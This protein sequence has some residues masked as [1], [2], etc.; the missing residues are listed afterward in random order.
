MAGCNKDVTGGMSQE[1]PA[2]LSAGSVC[3]GARS[4]AV[5]DAE[6][7]CPD[8]RT[9]APGQ[10]SLPISLR[11]AQAAFHQMAHQYGFELWTPTIRIAVPACIAAG[12][13]SISF[14]HMEAMRVV[15]IFNSPA[16]HV[17]GE[18]Q[19]G[20]FFSHGGAPSFSESVRS[21]PEHG[22][23]AA[24]R[25]DLS[26]SADACSTDLSSACHTHHDSMLQ[27][28]GRGCASAV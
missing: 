27:A 18:H 25:A 1:N 4:R 10:E 22:N 20:V 12:D 21:V 17:A 8:S 26:A 23:A 3:E 19:Q 11:L 7:P 28:S 6:N 9:L 16:A 24:R 13:T 5:H 2:R 14:Q 15:T